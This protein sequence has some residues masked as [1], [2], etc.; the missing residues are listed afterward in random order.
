MSDNVCTTRRL[1]VNAYVVTASGRPTFPPMILG[2]EFGEMPKDPPGSQMRYI[3]NSE[4]GT[5][6]LVGWE[7]VLVPIAIL[8]DALHREGVLNGLRKPSREQLNELRAMVDKLECLLPP[9]S[10]EG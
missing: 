6:D 7:A 10:V 1:H 8:Q 9:E 5:V 2:P 4:N 3:I